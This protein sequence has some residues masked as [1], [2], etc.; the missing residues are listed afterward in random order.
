MNDIEE[1][2]LLLSE[3]EAEFAATLQPNDFWAWWTSDREVPAKW[4]A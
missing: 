2:I 3:K 4:Q 1:T